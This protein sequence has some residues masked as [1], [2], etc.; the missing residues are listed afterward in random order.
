M[1]GATRS[2]P[3]GDPRPWGILGG[4]FDPIH[5]GHLAVAEQT[6]QALD[7]AGVV[8]VPAAQPPCGR[9]RARVS[10][11]QPRLRLG[12]SAGRAFTARSL[13]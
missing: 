9:G 13:R 10:W 3:V 11:P 1:T 2:D 4:T 8:F 12:A 6:R 7:L 5:L